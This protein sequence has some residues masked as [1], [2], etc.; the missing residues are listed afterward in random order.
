MKGNWGAAMGPL[1]MGTLGVSASGP[2]PPSSC[3]ASRLLCLV[4]QLAD[5]RPPWTSRARSIRGWGPA[6]CAGETAVGDACPRLAHLGAQSRLRHRT[7]YTGPGRR[8]TASSSGSS[9]VVGEQLRPPVGDTFTTT[10]CTAA[11]I[12]SIGTPHAIRETGHGT[13]PIPRDVCRYAVF[14]SSATRWLAGSALSVL[15]TINL[16]AVGR[17]SDLGD[18]GVGLGRPGLYRGPSRK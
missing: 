18:D 10:G 3:Q 15:F 16:I 2:K 4:K 6:V 9:I 17:N 11:E 5:R 12:R 1:T 8:G 7:S 13:V 14:S